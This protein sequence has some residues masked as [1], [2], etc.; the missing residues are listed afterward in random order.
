MQKKL[1]NIGFE[2]VAAADRIIG[3]LSP[4]SAPM[5]RTIADARARSMLIDATYGRKTRSVI[6]MDSGHVILCASNPQT[7]AVRMNGGKDDE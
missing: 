2:N 7:I 1:V 4:E 6:I 3:V 5:K